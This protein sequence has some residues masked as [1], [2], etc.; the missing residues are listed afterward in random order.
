[1]SKLIGMIEEEKTK[2]EMHQRVDDLQENLAD[3]IETRRDKLQEEFKRIKDVS[4]VERF[5][6]THLFLVQKVIIAEIQRTLKC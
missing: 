1:M 6:E 5:I 3:I 4:V 2:E